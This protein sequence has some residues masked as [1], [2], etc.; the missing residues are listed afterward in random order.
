MVFDV[1]NWYANLKGS[2][3]TN[4]LLEWT[5][6]SLQSLSC[7]V[8]ITQPLHTLSDEERKSVNLH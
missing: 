4:A 7:S 2:I 5:K 3:D 6:I 1:V 8:N